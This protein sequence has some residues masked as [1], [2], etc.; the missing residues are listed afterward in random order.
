MDKVCLE[1]DSRTGKECLTQAQR[2]ASI[3]WIRHT[4]LIVFAY[5]GEVNSYAA[6]GSQIKIDNCPCCQS[7]GSLVGHGVYWRKPRDGKQAYRIAIRRWRCKRCGRTVS[8]L[9]DFLL[10]FRW[11]LLAVISQV[12][13]RRAEEG[14]SWNALEAEWADTPVVRTMQ[15]W[16]RS[17]GE[18]AG[19]WLGMAQRVLA[20]QDS[21]SG[22][23]E[24]QGEAARAPNQVQALLSAAGY[25]LAWG[26]TRWRELA[27]YGWNERL[28]FLWLWG[29]GRGLGRL[30]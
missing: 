26:K 14:A 15:R 10:R 4:G 30:V 19:E 2:L 18:Q 9:P 24:P 28:R 6:A 27:G 29:S 5:A 7:E 20:E 21:G 8:A 25:L 12:L 17:F 16:W 13:V 3:T 23:L 1:A 22:W 11:Y